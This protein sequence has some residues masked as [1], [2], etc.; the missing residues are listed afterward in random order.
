MGHPVHMDGKASRE[1]L[2]FGLSSDPHCSHSLLKPSITL[3]F[4]EAGVLSAIEIFTNCCQSYNTD[5]PVRFR[6]SV[7]FFLCLALSLRA[8][9]VKAVDLSNVQQRIKLRVPRAKEPNCVPQPCVVTRETSVDDCRI[10]AKSLRVVLN[11]VTPNQITLDPFKAEFRILNTGN[12]PIEV[13]VSPHLSDLQPPGPLR[14]FDYMSLALR[15]HLSAVG[16]VQATGIGWAELYGTGEHPDTILTLEPGH[17][18]RV[19][20]KVKLHTWPS[21]SLDASLNGDFRLYKNVF[22]PEANGGFVDSLDL[23]PNR[24]TLMNTVDVHFSPIHLEAHPPQGT[25]P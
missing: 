1:N 4:P 9:E 25:R 20:T 21:Q 14:E 11:R 6:C 16:R 13:P 15:I 17:W 19:T 2:D 3:I 10:E 5:V 7:L 18:I 22:K 23:C 12:E 24:A 8:Q